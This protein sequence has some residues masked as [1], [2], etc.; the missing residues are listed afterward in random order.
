MAYCFAKEDHVPEV[1][2]RIN[3]FRQLMINSPPCPVIGGRSLG[4]Q[5]AVQA[6]TYS[7]AK[8]LILFAYPLVAG[9]QNNFDELLNLGTDMDV[10]SIVGDQDVQ[11]PEQQLKECR[12]NMQARTWRI[13][14]AKG[15]HGFTMG[16]AAESTPICEMA[17]QLAARWNMR[18]DRDPALSELTLNYN[19]VTNQC[20][21]TGWRAP[22]PEPARPDTRVTINVAGPRIWRGGG[23]FNLVLPQ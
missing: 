17:G 15:D 14:V 23:S 7:S 12:A 4:A 20:D 3:I 21:W 2:D 16:G 9:L 13:K 22:D 11:A 18:D 10:L 5:I 6:A 19:T 1:Q 8:K